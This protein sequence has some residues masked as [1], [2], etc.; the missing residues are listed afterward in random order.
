M[1]IFLY[2]HITASLAGTG[3]ERESLWAEGRAMLS[4]LREDLSRIPDIQVTT[5][6]TADEESFRVAARSA[7]Y[8]VVIAPEFDDILATRCR[9]V[10]EAGGNLLGPSPAAIGLTADKLVLAEHLR[11]RSV[12]TP[13]CRP[14]RHG[15]PPVLPFPLVWKPRY[16]AGSQA[17]FL[18]RDA[19]ELSQAIAQA[20]AEG[21]HDESLVQRY[22]SGMAASV[23]FLAGPQQV[24]PLLPT[25]QKLSDDGRFHYR[26][27]W[28]P[29]PLPLA[30]RAERLAQRALATVEGL[31]GYVGVDIVL[32]AAADGSEDWVIEINPRLTTSYI[33]Q[34]TLIETNLAQAMLRVAQGETLPPLP[35]RPGIVEFQADGRVAYR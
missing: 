3:A 22:V 14:W 7:D 31:C 26:G 10:R 32:G 9:W 2:E 5:L 11:Q 16:G 12:P 35:K 18:V 29:L 33:G 24:L 25:A 30:V 27:G 34:R 20:A 13:E 21:W 4:A 6:D 19:E 23:A 1:R 17:T 28:L 8:S 15:E